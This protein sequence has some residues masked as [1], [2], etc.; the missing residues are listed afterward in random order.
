[1]LFRSGGGAA[2]H[3][4]GVDCAEFHHDVDDVGVG[5]A[6]R[7]NLT[8]VDT[9]EDHSAVS[10]LTDG[11]TGIEAGIVVVCF[12]IDLAVHQQNGTEAAAVTDVQ[13][14]SFLLG[15]ILLGNHQNVI[16]VETGKAL[17]TGLLTGFPDGLS[18]GQ[19]QTQRMGTNNG[20]GS[21][22]VEEGLCDH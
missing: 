9:D 8:A 5:T 12:Q 14:F 11:S 21:S 3:V 6:G 2:V 10:P 19:N 17:Q 4:A 22:V 18:V 20:I 15:Q 7:S 13:L 1:M 16:L